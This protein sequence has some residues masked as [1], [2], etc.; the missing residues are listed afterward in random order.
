MEPGDGTAAQKNV[1][2]VRRN[3][4]VTKNIME[5]IIQKAI[6]GGWNPKGLK[7]K[8]PTD[9]MYAK[10]ILMTR[11]DGIFL[12]PLFWQAL[13]KSLGI[14]NWRHEWDL[15]FNHLAEGNSAESFFGKY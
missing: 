2:I 1:L 3:Y 12:D 4:K 11:G 15:F 13:T 7:P 14:M 9:E 8:R 5:K 10:A 6:E